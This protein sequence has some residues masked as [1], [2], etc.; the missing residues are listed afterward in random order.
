MNLLIATMVLSTVVAIRSTWSPCGWSMLSTLTPLSERSR[1]KGYFGIVSWYI[2]GAGLGGALLGLV[3][4]A[5]GSFVAL[6]DPSNT[7]QLT[8]GFLA[9]LICIISD[10]PSIGLTLPKHT[11][12]VNEDWIDLY[13]RWIS[14][15]GFGLQIGFGF[16][17]Y[18]TTSGVY[19]FALLTILLA[20]PFDAFF[21]GTGFGFVR[22]ISILFGVGIDTPKSLA[23]FHK[24]FDHLGELAQRLTLVTMVFVAIWLIGN[25]WWPL[26][27]LVGIPMLIITTFNELGLRSHNESIA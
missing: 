24:K 22:G 25:L 23:G 21:I 8:I 7:V 13:R 18:I 5:V 3:M 1:G 10:S 12:Q 20:R 26:S 15:S 19:L 17:T 27:I 11:R 14:A 9:C 16:A 4:A 2:L 6:F